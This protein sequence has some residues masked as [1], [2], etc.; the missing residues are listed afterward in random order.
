LRQK[1]SIED[2]QGASFQILTKSDRAL[3]V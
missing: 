2:A 3:W 1:G